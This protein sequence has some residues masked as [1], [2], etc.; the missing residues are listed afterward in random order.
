MVAERR[1]L[2]LELH[3]AAGGVAWSECV[4]GEQPNY[5]AET[6]DTAW[7][8]IQQ[9]VA[10]RV[11]GVRLA[12]PEEIEAVLDRDFRGHAMA[13]AAVEMGCWALAATAEGFAE[14][15]DRYVHERH[16]A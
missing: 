9:W 14:Y 5:S 7:Y 8:A 16:A 3:D 1:V 2:L 15:L 10:P 6:I 13:K 11:L 4:A 12:S